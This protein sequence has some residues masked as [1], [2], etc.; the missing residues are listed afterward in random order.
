MI[1]ALNRLPFNRQCVY[2]AKCPGLPFGGQNYNVV[3]SYIQNLFIPYSS[4]VHMNSIS[5]IISV[6]LFALIVSDFC[7]P[8]I[9]IGWNVQQS[10]F[11]SSPT[12]VHYRSHLN[13]QHLWRQLASVSCEVRPS[14]VAVMS[15][16]ASASTFMSFAALWSPSFPSPLSHHFS[17][18]LCSNIFCL[19]D[20]RNL[21]VIPSLDRLE[22]LFI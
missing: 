16:A 1:F 3:P 17:F 7:I 8:R 10:N 18:S 12:T 11:H 4:N 15:L 5:Q 13:Q 19:F 9:S 2:F 14:L 22:H 21:F 20:W 6:N